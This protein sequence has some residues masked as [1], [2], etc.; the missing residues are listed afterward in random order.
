MSYGK[1]EKM[2]KLYFEVKS[3]TKIAHDTYEMMLDSMGEHHGISNPGQFV[4][5]KL[6]GFFLRRP[7]S[8]CDWDEK[9]ITII[10][11]TIGAG[12]HA[13]AEA[14]KGMLLDILTPLGNGFDI[15]DNGNVGI[16]PILIGGG[17]GVPPLYGLCKALVNEGKK[18]VVIAGFNTK[19]E[20]FYAENFISAGA[21]LILTTADGSEGFK[22]LVTD[23]LKTVNGSYIFC[24]GPE[25][26]LKA[27]DDMTDRDTDGQ[28][29]FEERMGCG[30]GAC[31]GCSC[32]TKHGSKR[33]CKEGPVLKRG[34][35]IW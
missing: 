10:Y 27:V 30:F 16:R 13:L 1:D 7:I 19:S 22:G 3:N 34:E 35:I 20:I 33:I 29:S 18:P 32:M 2:K 8:V 14:K 23:A 15:H 17:A 28:M 6:N 12:T 31:M 4:N 11:K 24:C 26:M 9:G 25:G 21:E 5:I